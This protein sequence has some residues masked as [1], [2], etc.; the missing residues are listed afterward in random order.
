MLENV[1]KFLEHFKDDF[2]GK[3]KKYFVHVGEKISENEYILEE[4]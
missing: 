1:G 3:F 4:V 2:L